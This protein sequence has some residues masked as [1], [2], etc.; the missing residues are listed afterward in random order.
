MKK[1]SLISIDA[2]PSEATPLICQNP[3][4][5]NELHNEEAPDGE[6]HHYECECSWCLMY[7]WSLNH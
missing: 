7:H 5:C 2:F 4:T 6:L 3:D 1:S